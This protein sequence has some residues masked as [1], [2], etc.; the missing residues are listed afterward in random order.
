[1]GS[2]I[3]TG[4]A[5]AVATGTTATVL[6]FMG[7]TALNFGLFLCAYIVLTA[8][9]LGWR[10]VWLGAVLATVF[11]QVLQIVGST[12]IAHVKHS[13]D[14]YGFFAIV[15]TLLSW[16]YLGA[17]LF[18]LAAEIN[19]VRRYRLWPRSVT[20]PPLT[21]GDRATFERLAAMEVRRPEMK[22]TV[23]FP[24]EADRDPL[25]E[26]RHRELLERYPAHGG[27]AARPSV[28]EDDLHDEEA[29]PEEGPDRRVGDDLHRAQ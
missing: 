19:V 17:H 13:S 12:Y 6:A 22:V 28:V 11:W 14:T 23:T 29:H 18:L 9:P 3:L 20:Q 10:D 7:A 16:L 8:E 5:T 15:L 21:A 25:V 2:T 4:F 24:E 26:E 1:V 27:T